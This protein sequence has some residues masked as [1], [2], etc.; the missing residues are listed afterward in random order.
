MMK[1][2]LKT[3]ITL[4]LIFTLSACEHKETSQHEASKANVATAKQQATTVTPSSEKKKE[5]VTTTIAAT[6]LSKESVANSQATTATKEHAPI[7]IG[8]ILPLEHQALNDIVAGFSEKL[9]KM[10]GESVQIKIMNA[11]GDVN[12]Q[13]AIIQQ[14]HDQHYDLIV[15]VATGTT[16]MTLSMVHDTPIVGLAADL[17]EADRQK[18]TPCNI[19][20]VHDEIPPRKLIE[21]LHMTH[22][23]LKKLTLIHSTSDKIFPDVQATIAV[24]K[25]LGIEVKALM[26]ATLPELTSATQALSNETQ[27]I[28]ILKDNLIAS[29]IAT[30]AKAA[31]DKHIPLFTSDEGSVQSGA[32]FS[33][34]VREKQIG[35]EG[36]VL[37]AAVIA[38]D[39]ACHI[40]NVEMRK[41]TVFI[42]KKSLEKELQ[43]GNN[44]ETAAKKLNYQVAYVEE[45]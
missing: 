9:P 19:V 29:G 5:A 11:Q 12:L 6:A 31:N 38:G 37:A 14:M 24:G 23:K 32:G 28:F 39:S 3:A 7:K 1:T 33:L 43:D 41:L 10:Y 15:P 16:Q 2:Y 26:V 34:G 35:E 30:L 18:L 13:R 42:N 22:P 8:I 4:L 44:I 36:A 40:P 20:I 25:Q 17:S 21:F 27:G 45:K